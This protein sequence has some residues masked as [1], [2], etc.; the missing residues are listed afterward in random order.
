MTRFG[1]LFD[2]S[3]EQMLAEAFTKALQ[4]VDKGLDP[5]RLEAF[6]YGNCMGSLSGNEIPSGAVLTNAIGLPGKP[7]SRIENGCPTGSD[8]FRHACMGVASGLYDVA[9]AIGVDKMTDKP[10]RKSLL[11]SGRI[12]HPTIMYSTTAPTLFAPQIH[13]HMEEFGTTKE[14]LAMVGVKAHQNGSLNPNAHYRNLISIEDVLNSPLVC[15]PLN[16][17][18][19]CP[20]TDGAACVIVCRP[21]IAHE[22]T[23]EPIYVAG[24]GLATDP[25]YYHEKE[26]L[27]GW[28]CTGL[29]ARQA[30][31]MAGIGPDDIDV[32]EIH[33]C[34]SGVEIMNYEDLGFCDK[35]LGGQLIQDGETTLQGRIPVNPSGGL[36]AKGHPVG[37]TGIAQIL[38]L[39]NQLRERTGER[40]VRIHNGY[41]LQ[42]NV[43]GY[44]ISVSVV[45]ILT[46][47]P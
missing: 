32:A 39:Y 23:A 31:K 36:M 19:C 11:E 26:V 21:E 22:F 37:A 29:A 44:S 10:A 4:D 7:A 14:Q 38:E 5:D 9:A 35:G 27:T 1:E 15:S 43:G 8:T 18:D 34:F 40:Q 30:Y 13:R 25:L 46:R 45:S 28:A 24:L 33:D 20:Q 41:G 6:W 17:F 12:G 2:Q 42:H 3:V 16:L 47:T